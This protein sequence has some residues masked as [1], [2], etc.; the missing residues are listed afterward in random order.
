MTEQRSHS[1]SPNIEENSSP[2]TQSPQKIPAWRRFRFGKKR[3]D[4][5]LREKRKTKRFK[6]FKRKTK[7]TK[8]NRRPPTNFKRELLAIP[9][10]IT[11]FRILTI[12]FILFFVSYESRWHSFIASLFFTFACFSDFF[13]GYFARKLNQITI[14]GKLL[15]PLADKLVVSSTLIILIGMG[16]V[17]DWLV[18]LLLAREFAITGLRGIAASEKMIIPASPLGKYKTAFQMAAIFYLLVHY[19]YRIN[20]YG[21]FALEFSFHDVGIVLL[22]ISLFYS[23]ISAFDYFWKFA[24]Q[25]NQRYTHEQNLPNPQ[26]SKAN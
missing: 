24:T 20:F 7:R 8:K 26:K 6:K 23:L 15:D 11:Y 5:L 13:D 16:R 17:P 18:I 9:N 10:I 3:D 1:T 19:S 12:P 22:Y 2:Q 4:A 14:L 25:I 21:L